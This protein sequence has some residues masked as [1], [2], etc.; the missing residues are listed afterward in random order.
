MSLF[1]SLHSDMPALFTLSPT[2]LL[3]STLPC[4]F[5]IR[6]LDLCAISEY[7]KRRKM[8]AERQWTCQCTGHINLTHEEAL[9]SEQEN[10]ELLS[11]KFPEYFEKPVLELVHHSKLENLCIIFLL[12]I[13]HTYVHWG[14]VLNETIPFNRD[15]YDRIQ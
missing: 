14:C 15:I 5:K 12:H 3:F 1:F 8:Y 6:F 7:E 9:R 13:Q 2:H 11:R 4:K 10:Y